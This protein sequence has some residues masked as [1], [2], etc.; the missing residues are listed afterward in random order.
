[1]SLPI[2]MVTRHRKRH[3]YVALK[4][5]ESIRND[6]YYKKILLRAIQILNDD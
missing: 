2:A 3:A 4:V 5:A 6:C 1:M